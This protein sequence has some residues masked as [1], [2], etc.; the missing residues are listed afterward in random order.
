MRC[1]RRCWS[2]PI[3]TNRTTADSTLQS[4]S[5]RN[6]RPITRIQTLLAILCRT[7][8]MIGPF[9][10]WLNLW[11]NL[12]SLRNI[13]CVQNFTRMC[14]T[15]R[16]NFSARDIATERSTVLRDWVILM[17]SIIDMSRETHGI[18]GSL[19]LKYTYLYLKIYAGKIR[20][21]SNYCFKKKYFFH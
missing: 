10:M 9:T 21:S 16:L 14:F 6:T 15:M 7:R 11:I 5:R 3:L 13:L 20:H 1:F 19:C 18:T 17:S 12:I 2:Y 8:T 4:I